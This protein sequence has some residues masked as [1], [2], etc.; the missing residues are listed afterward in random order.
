MD[1]IFSR[2]IDG[3]NVMH[4]GWQ[5][6]LSFSDY[7]NIVLSK[8]ECNDNKQISLWKNMFNKGNVFEETV[9]LAPKKQNIRFFLFEFWKPHLF[10]FLSLHLKTLMLNF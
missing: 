3:S 2:L 4:E 1:P 7:I 9:S 5:L 10:H 8:S 6:F